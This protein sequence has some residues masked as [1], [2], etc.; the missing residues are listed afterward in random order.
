MLQKLSSSFFGQREP[1]NGLSSIAPATTSKDGIYFTHRRQ[2]KK[3]KVFPPFFFCLF[4]SLK[5]GDKAVHL[6]ALPAAKAAARLGLTHSSS[7]KEKDALDLIPSHL[8][9]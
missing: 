1:C 2:K 6:V 9:R 3:K 7:A 8:S 5:T 4:L